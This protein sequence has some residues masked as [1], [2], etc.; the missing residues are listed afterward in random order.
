MPRYL[1]ILLCSVPLLLLFG[2]CLLG[3]NR[4]NQTS[5]S[6]H[7]D[8][9][10]FINFNS[11]SSYTFGDMMKWFWEM[12][13]VPW[14]TWVEDPPEPKPPISVSAGELGVTFINQS[15]MLVQA[16]GVNF[17]TDPIWSKN[18]G[19]V[20]WLGLK[21]VRAPGVKMEDLPKIDVI[22][23]SHDHY[24]HMDLPTLEALWARDQPII[25]VGLGSKSLLE[26]RG[27]RNVVEMDWWQEFNLTSTGMKFV[28]VPAR[29]A[30]GRGPFSRDKSLWGGF[31][32]VTSC[33]RI[34]FA[35]DTGY[36]SH[37]NAIHE[38]FP[39]FRLAMLPIGT[40]EK[41]WFMQ[42]Q[43]MNPADAV[44][45]HWLLRARQ[46]IGMHYG[47]FSFHTEQAI[48][49]HEGDLRNALNLEGVPQ[50]EFLVL[51]FGEGCFVP[52]DLRH[53]YQ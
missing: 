53:R 10:R 3:A 17:L 31:V 14:P 12:K 36:G 38:R 29:H 1:K 22:L 46:S 27:L 41:R 52:P 48:D 4:P 9:H 50:S 32:V 26:S 28:F 33:G 5:L 40:Y 24:D 34:Y 16:D 37:L 7:F 13:V 47:T 39:D 20:S 23:L 6:D 43:H 35:G 19:P 42:S 25:L 18:A 11:E 51:K 44:K 30:S 45:A 8:G 2:A 49:A 15:T 21:R